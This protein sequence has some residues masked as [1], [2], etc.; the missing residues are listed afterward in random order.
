MFPKCVLEYGFFYTAKDD[1]TKD[2]LSIPLIIAIEAKV[3]CDKNKIKAYI[4]FEYLILF[5]N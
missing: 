1:S 2:R 4:E 3:I 5:K